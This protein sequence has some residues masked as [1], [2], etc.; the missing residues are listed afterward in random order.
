MKYN[1]DPNLSR[2]RRFIPNHVKS[3]CVLFVLEFVGASTRG[4]IPT[5][6]A[7]CGNGDGA[8]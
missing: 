7:V 2:G 1:P 5:T 3:L 6:G 4:G 8:I